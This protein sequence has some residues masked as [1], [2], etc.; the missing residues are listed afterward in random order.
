[1]GGHDIFNHS[2]QCTKCGTNITQW[3]S[4][5]FDNKNH[6]FR[7]YDTVDNQNNIKMY[8]GAVKVY[9]TCDKCH[10]KHTGWVVIDDGVYLGLIDIKNEEQ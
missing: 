3:F 9:G 2:K 8:D 10:A 6:V 7:L 1:M 4:T 5:V